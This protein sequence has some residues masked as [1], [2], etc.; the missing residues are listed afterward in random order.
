MRASAGRRRRSTKFWRNEWGCTSRTTPSDARCT[1]STT[2][3]SVPA[4]CWSLTRTERKKRWIRRKIPRL[5]ER[6][7]IP[8]E[9][10]TDLLLF[11]PL[12]AGWAPRGAPL[13]VWLTGRNARRVLFG[14]VNLRTGHLVPLC[15]IRQ[16]ATDF[17]A[18]L[19]EVRR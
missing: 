4:T 7:V 12:R 10:E 17:C 14:A 13:K 11:P 8:A 6:S 2:H 1:G 9:D 15:R 19:H 18:F 5:P 16:K 3:G